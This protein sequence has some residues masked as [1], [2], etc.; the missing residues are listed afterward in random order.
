MALGGI[1]REFWYC[2]SRH[3]SYTHGE[4]VTT[5]TATMCLYACF[6]EGMSRLSAYDN[7]RGT[8]DP[9]DL[10]AY[11]MNDLLKLRRALNSRWARWLPRNHEHM[12]IPAE[13]W[14]TATK[15][16]LKGST[17]RHTRAQCYGW[18]CHLC[19]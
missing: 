16:P 13:P 7:I 9:T 3:Q 10:A 1:V 19:K 5:G 11:D 12:P 6:N 17:V 8:C 2:V 15:L 4:S 18:W 14:I